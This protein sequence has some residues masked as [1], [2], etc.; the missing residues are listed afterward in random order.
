MNTDLSQRN[1]PKFAQIVLRIVGEV[2]QLR[3]SLIMLLA[4]DAKWSLILFCLGALTFA[5]PAAEMLPLPTLNAFN[6]SEA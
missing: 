4:G 5:F 6:H 2:A 1:D 3:P